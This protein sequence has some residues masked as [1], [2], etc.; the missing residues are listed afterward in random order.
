LA[1]GR[2]R[3]EISTRK[4]AEISDSP[5]VASL[6]TDNVISGQIGE[7]LPLATTHSQSRQKS[8]GIGNYASSESMSETQIWV[9]VELLP[10]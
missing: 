10:E 4:Q 6:T 7:W 3:I 9:K 1:Q 5:A 2:V 8:A